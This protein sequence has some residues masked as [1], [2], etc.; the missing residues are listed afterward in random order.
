M[1][2]PHG[3][4]VTVIAAVAENGV[5]GVENRLP[6]HLP[7]DLRHFRALTRGHAIIM[8]RR[9]YESIGRPL[10]E[11]NNIVITRNPDFT[12][13]GCQ[14]VHSLEQALAAATSQEVFVIGGAEVY[15]QALPIADKLV[16]TVVHAAVAGD[17]SFPEYPANAWRE[18]TR[19]RHEADE[20]HA[21]AYSFVTYERSPQPNP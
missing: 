21:Y 2:S 5:I 10:P 17:V 12:A 1:T 11:R 7:D 14:V 9:N 18:I 19:E 20:R 4:K 3:H 16:I 6:W 13:P 15:R 8:G